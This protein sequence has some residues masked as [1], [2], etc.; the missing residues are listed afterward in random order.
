MNAGYTAILDVILDRQQALGLDP[1]DVNIPGNSSRT[2]GTPAT[3]PYPSK[4]SVAER[5]GKTEKTQQHR[6]AKGSAR[7]SAAASALRSSVSAEV[8]DGQ[9][10]TRTTIER[11]LPRAS[12]LGQNTQPIT[13]NEGGCPSRR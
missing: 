7:R 2:G 12:Y 5:I 13:R 1:I 3:L 11:Q 6:I 9:I 8:F 10:L 4:K